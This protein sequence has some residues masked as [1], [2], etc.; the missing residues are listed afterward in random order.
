MSPLNKS[1]AAMAA[2]SII[3][4]FCRVLEYDKLK[5]NKNAGGNCEG[6]KHARNATEHHV[7]CKIKRSKTVNKLAICHLFEKKEITK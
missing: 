5:E 4:K 2:T 1:A 6:C 3:A 7:E